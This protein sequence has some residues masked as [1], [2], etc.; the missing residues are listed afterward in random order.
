MTI[1]WIF[2]SFFALGIK[3]QIWPLWLSIPFLAFN[4]D[5]FSRKSSF[6]RFGF[7]QLYIYYIPQSKKERS[8]SSLFLSV[9]RLI[10]ISVLFISHWRATSSGFLDVHLDQNA[11][12]FVFF[13]L[14]PSCSSVFI[15]SSSL[16]VTVKVYVYFVFFLLILAVCPF[17]FVDVVCAV[18][19]SSL[20]LSKVFDLYFWRFASFPISSSRL[21]SLWYLE[22]YTK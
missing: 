13:N 2:L 15:F 1:F 5:K 11:C 12:D 10:I 4:Y 19:R 14:S 20:F 3:L 17:C 16:L 18:L 9:P 21:Y 7:Q 6:P 8:F 22:W